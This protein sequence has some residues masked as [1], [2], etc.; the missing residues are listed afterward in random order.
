MIYSANFTIIL[1]CWFCIECSKLFSGA[2]KFPTWELSLP[3]PA[4]SS[5]VAVKFNNSISTCKYFMHLRACRECCSRYHVAKMLVKCRASRLRTIADRQHTQR[6]GKMSNWKKEGCELGIWSGKTFFYLREREIYFTSSATESYI[7]F[8][9]SF[10][11]LLPAFAF[12]CSPA[13]KTSGQGTHIDRSYLRWKLFDYVWSRGI[14]HFISFRKEATWQETRDSS[15][16]LCYR[17]SGF[18]WSSV[19]EGEIWEWGNGFWGDF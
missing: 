6:R 18:Y 3:P 1:G 14:K 12:S 8:Y 11:C 19:L 4:F 13:V 10:K 5:L 7:R 16:K 15:V 2:R 17:K 9:A